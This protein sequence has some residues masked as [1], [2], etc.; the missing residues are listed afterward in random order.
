[1]KGSRFRSYPFERDSLCAIKKKKFYNPV[2]NGAAKKLP[3][4]F[5]FIVFLKD[6]NTSV[7][8][9]GIIP[10]FGKKVLHF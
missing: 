4:F 5:L 8:Q 2:F 6:K 1:M 9:S 7:S 3:G 10:P